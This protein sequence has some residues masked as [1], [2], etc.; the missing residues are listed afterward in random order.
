MDPKTNVAAK[1]LQRVFKRVT[2]DLSMIAER[3]IEVLS[4]AY[5]E[6]EDRAAGS[7]V[8]HIAFRFGVRVA[9]GGR[10]GVARAG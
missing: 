5:E 6:R 4:I 3:D 1:V 7:S 9:G 8:V 2:S 10:S